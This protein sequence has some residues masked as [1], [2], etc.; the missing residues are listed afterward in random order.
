MPLF[1]Y[2]GAKTVGYISEDQPFPAR[3]CSTVP[4]ITTDNGLTFTEGTD[5]P[6]I[7]ANSAITRKFS[8]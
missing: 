7:Y 4:K 5:P 6:L 8:Q 2:Q 1:R 3:A